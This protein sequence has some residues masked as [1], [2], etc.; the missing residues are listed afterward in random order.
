M[1]YRIWMRYIEERFCFGSVCATDPARLFEGGWNQRPSP[2]AALWRLA[3]AQH[4]AGSWAVREAEWYSTQDCHPD[5][6]LT[7]H[8]AIADSWI[9]P[10]VPSRAFDG[11]THIPIS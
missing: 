11:G 2:V 7:N 9:E 3:N 6:K 4:L 10:R 8:V 1:I 5:S